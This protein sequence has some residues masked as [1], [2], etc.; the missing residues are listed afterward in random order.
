[1]LRPSGNLEIMS[2]EAVSD[3]VAEELLLPEEN[4]LVSI[5]FTACP[6]LFKKG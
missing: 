3:L 2:K 4:G 1:M 5:L 6:F